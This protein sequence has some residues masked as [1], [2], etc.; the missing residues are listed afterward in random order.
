M[1]L[2]VRYE[3]QLSQLIANNTC[4]GIPST[5]WTFVTLTE[6]SGGHVHCAKKVQ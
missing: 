6:S 3:Q 2:E 5:F 1:E 4:S